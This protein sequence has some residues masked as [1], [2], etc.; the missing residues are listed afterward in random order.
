MK[1]IPLISAII[2]FLIGV[3]AYEYYVY[4]WS[5]DETTAII[6]VDVIIIY[7]LLI[8][9]SGLIYYLVKKYVAKQK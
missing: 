2:V 5:K 7:P 6:R 4:Q 3:I 1:R 9:F 8:L